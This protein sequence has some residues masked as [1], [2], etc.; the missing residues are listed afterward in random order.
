MK[1][2]IFCFMLFPILISGADKKKSKIVGA[3]ELVTFTSVVDG[4][5]QTMNISEMDNASHLKIFS[6]EHVVFVGS[7]GNG[8]PVY[9]RATYTLKEGK[10]TGNIKCH[11][12]KELENTVFKSNIEIRNDSLFQY[13][14]RGG[15]GKLDKSNYF[16]EAFVKVN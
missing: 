13:W 11:Y 7:T 9:G 4:K 14:T 6:E 1:I 12:V 3:W 8:E 10:Y 16:M 2:L 15:N 5:S